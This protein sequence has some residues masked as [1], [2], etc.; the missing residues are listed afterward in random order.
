MHDI[1]V[2]NN[3]FKMGGSDIGPQWFVRR[4]TR[5]LVGLKPTNHVK[6]RD[7]LAGLF[8]F[9]VVVGFFLQIQT[10]LNNFFPVHLSVISPHHRRLCF[11]FWTFVCSNCD[12][13]HLL[14]TDKG[15]CKSTLAQNTHNHLNRLLY[16]YKCK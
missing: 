11:Y 2:L 7:Q 3:K 13:F 6:V 10:S 5:S 15:W 14:G 12:I 4:R 1:K 8:G 9:F 16:L